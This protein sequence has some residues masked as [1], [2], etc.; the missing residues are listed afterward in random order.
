MCQSDKHNGRPG[1]SK[2]FGFV[3]F[4][5]LE[6][7][8]NAITQMNGQTYFQ[9]PLYVDYAQ[10]KEVREAFIA[11]NFERGLPVWGMQVR[12]ICSGRE[13]HPV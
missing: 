9:K 8:T 6:E 10:K 5:S 12:L 4:S 2:G 7:A 11:K 1:R 13:K 3:C